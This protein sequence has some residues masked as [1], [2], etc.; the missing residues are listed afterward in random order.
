MIRRQSGVA[1]VLVLWVITL[2]AVIAGNFAYSMRGEAQIARN[3]LSAAQAQA[4]ADAGVQ[5]AWFELMK[6]PTDVLRWTGDGAVHEYPMA[7]ATVRVSIQD[8]SGKININAA[9]EPLLHGLFKFVGLNDEVSAALVDAVQDWKDADK[10]RRLHGAEDHEYRAAGKRSVPSNAPFETVDELQ[11]VLG[12]SPDLYRKL[13]PLLTIYSGQAG[14]NATVA[15]RDVLMA[16]PDVSPALMGQYLAQRQSAM[17][18]NQ[19]VPYAAFPSLYTSGS[20]VRPGYAVRSEAKMVD[21][22]VF[23]RQAVGRLTQDPKRPVNV[24][25]WGGGEPELLTEK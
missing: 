8:E 15:P 1:L 19:K 22:A 16:L 14:V 7:G 17:D 5:R 11:G 23:V 3:L 10:L 24:L 21:G 20:A 2:L 25:A 9:P 6:P 12:M 13:A 18:A 4:Y